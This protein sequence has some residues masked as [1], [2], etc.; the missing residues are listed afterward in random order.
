MCLPPVAA[1]GAPHGNELVRHGASLIVGAG[2]FM[3]RFSGCRPLCE[4]FVC[5]TNIGAL[6]I[7]SRP[8]FFL[9]CFGCLGDVAA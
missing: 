6:I 7:R 3:V 9:A 5:S 8:A 4:G 1:E 2:A